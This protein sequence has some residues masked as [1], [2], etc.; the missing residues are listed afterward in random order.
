MKKYCLDT[1]VYIEAWNRY[2]SF[3][4]CP[5]YRSTLNELAME[6]I[7]F[8]PEE[9]K[10]ELD[11]IDD[12]LKNRIKWK[13]Y[14]F[15]PIDEIIQKTV[16]DI[17]RSHPKIISSKGKSSGADPWVIAC[18]YVNWAT[19][20]TKEVGTWSLKNPKI[21]DVCKDM[22]IDYIDDFEFLKEIWIWF[23]VKR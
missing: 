6:W 22:W 14:L 8:S 15:H 12:G 7:I 16:I 2:Y 21:P 17:M 20:V 1:N 9:V 3:D 11:R 5:E 19:L 18:A 13:T 10:I 23:T 4:L